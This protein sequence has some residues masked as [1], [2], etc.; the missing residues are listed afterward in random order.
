MF[1]NICGMFL[2]QIGKIMIV[3]VC[4]I[5]YTYLQQFAENVLG[6]ST[7]IFKTVHV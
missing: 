2:V 6:V 3:N 7:M 5:L 4:E 1:D